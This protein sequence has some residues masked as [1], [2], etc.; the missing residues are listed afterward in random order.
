MD[1]WSFQK[2]FFVQCPHPMPGA[3]TSTPPP[4][5]PQVTE[6]GEGVTDP[7]SPLPWGSPWQ[8]LALN[9]VGPTGMTSG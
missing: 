8:P 3:Y 4:C 2:L 7:A 9:L 5:S 1:C 6:L